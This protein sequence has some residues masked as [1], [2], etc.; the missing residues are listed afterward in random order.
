MSNEA[1][2]RLSCDEKIDEV[3][4]LKDI[5]RDNASAYN[6]CSSYLILC[7][8]LDHVIDGQPFETEDL[9]RALLNW[10]AQISDNEFWQANKESLYGLIVQ[11]CS[12]WMDSNACAKSEK[13]ELQTASHTLKSF[14]GEVIYHVAFIIGGYDHMRTVSLKWRAIDPE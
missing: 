8:I 10:T 4:K 5:C 13:P 11:G 2:I 12:A 1:A 6:F 7:N 9:A 14:Y 3:Q